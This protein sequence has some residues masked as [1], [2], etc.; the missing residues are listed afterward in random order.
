MTFWDLKAFT[1][2]LRTDDVAP[3]LLARLDSERYFPYDDDD[4]L[5]ADFA[6]FWMP[7]LF[8]ISPIWRPSLRPVEAAPTFFSPLCE[9]GP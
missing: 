8:A 9:I 6:F 4:G 2:P 7:E 5:L 1:T 3:Y